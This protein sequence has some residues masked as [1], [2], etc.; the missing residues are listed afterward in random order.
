MSLTLITG[1]MFSCK[2]TNLIQKGIMYEK[3][4]LNVCAIKFIDDNRYDA[5]KLVSHDKRFFRHAI[6]TRLL[7]TVNVTP[8]EVILIDEAQFFEDILVSD[9]WANRGKKVFMAG[10]ISDSNRQGF[11]NV[12]ECL[13]K[14]D[15]VLHLNAQCNHCRVNPASFTWRK[16]TNEDNYKQIVIGGGGLYEPVCRSCFYSKTKS[17]SKMYSNLN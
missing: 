9:E 13:P 4:G 6:S 10:L 5:H 2:T 1:P 15:H 3:Q 8:F 7:K 16:N 12:L 17:K 14:V 11:Q